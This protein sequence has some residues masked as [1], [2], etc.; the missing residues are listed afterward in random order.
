MAGQSGN[1]LHFGV[2]PNIDLIVRVPMSADDFVKRFAEHEVADLRA[3]VD[4]FESGAGQGVAEA[5]G[6]VCGAAAGDQEAVLVGRPG[7]GFDCGDVVVEF[8]DGLAG[9][10]VPD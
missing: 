2:L 6:A 10:A 5:D 9:V 7:H 8:E 1:F 4:R 3:G